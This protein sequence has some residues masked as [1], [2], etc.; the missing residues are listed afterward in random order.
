MLSSSQ[1]SLSEA[2][3]DPAN[4]KLLLKEVFSFSGASMGAVIFI[5][6]FLRIFI[7]REKE[8][9]VLKFADICMIFGI[10]ACLCT[11]GFLPWKRLESILYQVQFP[12][13]IFNLA[14]PLVAFAG[15]WA[16]VVNSLKINF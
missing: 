9:R 10:T 8:D 3:F 6:L 5:P 7:K 11:T 4:E 13:R 16:M 12:W 15:I 1:F 14:A 2:S